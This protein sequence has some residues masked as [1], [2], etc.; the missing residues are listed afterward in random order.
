MKIGINGLGRIGRL[1]LRA[2]LGGIPRDSKDQNADARLEIMHL[3]EVSGGANTTSHLLEFDS[4]HGRWRADIESDESS[5]TVDGRRMSFS[6]SEQPASVDW[7]AYGCDMV[8]ECTGRFRT[9]EK[10]AEYFTKG[11]QKVLVAAP[12]QDGQALNLV[13]GIND[14]LYNPVKHNIV[15]AASCTTNCLAPL[16]KVIHESIGIQ[17]GQITTIHDPTNTNVIVDAPH[18]DLRRARSAMTSLMPTT[19]GSAKAIGLIYPELKGKLNGH[20]VR[21]PVLNASLTDAVFELARPTSAQEVNAL[22]A[23]AANNELAGILGYEERPLVSADYVNDTRSSIIDAASTLVTDG[24]M[25][26]VYAWYDNEMGYACRMVD[27][28]TRVVDLNQ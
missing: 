27:V 14:H 12:V 18:K 3:N 9:P 22:F 28:A 6:S 2:A 4:V 11:V 19:T 20:A 26:K 21:A 24:T 1:V 10:L 7:G 8:L 23:E 25:L 5:I 13:Y 16:V 17:H 15:T